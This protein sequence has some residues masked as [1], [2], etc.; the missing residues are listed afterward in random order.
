MNIRWIVILVITLFAMN[1]AAQTEEEVV[2]EIRKRYKIITAAKDSYERT[3]IDYDWERD[4]VIP[5]LSEEE[6]EMEYNEQGNY[7]ADRTI[8]TDQDGNVRLIVI[9]DR[10]DVYQM[11]ETT[12]RHRE[13]YF[14]DDEMLFFY[15]EHTSAMSALENPAGSTSEERIY[16]HE[17]AIVRWLSKEAE[18]T[19][20]DLSAMANTKNDLSESSEYDLLDSYEE[21]Q[22]DW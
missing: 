15:F 4:E 14:W 18:G 9:D 2:K 21:L 3:M 16:L 10:T 12:Q 13:Y 17:G 1:A 8:Y 20:Q 22:P 11:P 19:D 7:T 5:S 6:M